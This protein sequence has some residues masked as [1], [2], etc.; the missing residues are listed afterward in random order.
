M[1]KSLITRVLLPA[2]IF[3]A[4]PGMPLLINFSGSGSEARDEGMGNGIQN[5]TYLHQGLHS[6]PPFL[7]LL[8]TGT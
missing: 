4:R 2:E 6:P 5:F 8:P 7:A 3:T 1:D